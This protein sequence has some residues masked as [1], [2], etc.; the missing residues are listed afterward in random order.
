[1]GFGVS[2]FGVSPFGVGL[3][4]GLRV[5]SAKAVSLNSVAVTFSAK[6]R[7]VDP[8][9]SDDV[10]NPA[11]WSLVVL[12][13]PTAIVR[14]AQYVTIDASEFV[15]TV[16]FDG[17]LTYGARYQIVVSE[18]VKDELAEEFIE[19]TGRIA[20]FDAL[21]APQRFTT[22][23][24]EASF[25]DLA[26]PFVSRYAGAKDRK[27]GTFAATSSGAL[28]LDSG[29]A[30]LAKRCFRRL[31]T[32]KGAFLH[33]PDYGLNLP[34]KTLIRPADLRKLQQSALIQLKQE[35]G[36]VSAQVSLQQ[37]PENPGVLLCGVKA[38]SQTGI[39][40]SGVVPIDLTEL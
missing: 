18:T 25:L 36:V 13:P 8:V 30:N 19:P 1:M 40:T 31:L 17:V 24:E 33:L 12:S 16:F 29:L 6:P 23:Q 32:R 28:E 3:T 15:A 4:S 9:S 38:K 20:A 11:N 5:V 27:L 22:A 7:G 26:N 37:S 10:L 35:L 39:E 14:L 34:I 21:G 2:P